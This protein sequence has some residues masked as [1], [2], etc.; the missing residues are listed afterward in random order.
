MTWQGHR[1]TLPGGNS[2]T[3]EIFFCFLGLIFLPTKNR[4]KPNSE[5]QPQGN[6]ETLP[7]RDYCFDPGHIRRTGKPM[8]PCSIAG[9]YITLIVKFLRCRQTASS[10]PMISIGCWLPNVWPFKTCLPHYTTPS[11]RSVSQTSFPGTWDN[12]WYR[13]MAHSAQQTLVD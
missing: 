13:V 9:K 4:M 1:E 6:T 11:K 10:I 2:A 3:K 8:L 12:S 5:K 7:Q